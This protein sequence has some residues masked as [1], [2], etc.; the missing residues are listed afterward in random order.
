[1]TITPDRRERIAAQMIGQELSKPE[2]GRGLE[3]KAVVIQWALDTFVPRPKFVPVWAW[4]VV[5]KWT[6]NQIALAIDV[7]HRKWIKRWGMK[8]IAANKNLLILEAS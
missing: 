2:G 8:W 4:R 1:M 7:I 5:T 3:R 6:A